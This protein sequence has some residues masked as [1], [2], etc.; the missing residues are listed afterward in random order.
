[1]WHDRHGDELR[2]VLARQI[3]GE[4]DGLEGTAEPSTPT[5]IRC[6]A[7]LLH[8][9]ANPNRTLPCYPVAPGQC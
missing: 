9:E 1:M 5:R 7:L 6:M 8:L 2:V 3:G 4:S